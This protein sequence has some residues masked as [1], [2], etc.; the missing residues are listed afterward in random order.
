MSTKVMRMWSRSV[1]NG[2]RTDL[3]FPAVNGE[4]DKLDGFVFSSE[5]VLMAMFS[6]GCSV[7]GVG[8]RANVYSR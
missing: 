3:R 7:R 2:S 8:G 1:R 5:Y 4:E 6:I